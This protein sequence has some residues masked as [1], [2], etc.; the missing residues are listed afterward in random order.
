MPRPLVLMLPPDGVRFLGCFD[1]VNFKE[2]WFSYPMPG[3]IEKVISSMWTYGYI[4]LALCRMKNGTYSIYQSIDLGRSWVEVYNTP[5][6]INDLFFIDFGWVLVSTEEGWLE[7]ND[8]GSTYHVLSIDAPNCKEVIRLGESSLMAY[9]GTRVWLSTNLGAEWTIVHTFSTESPAALA[10][11]WLRAVVGSGDTL[12]KTDNQGGS[13]EVL[14]RWPGEKILSV[15][16]TDDKEWT[17]EGNSYLVRTLNPSTGIVRHYFTENGGQSWSP[18]FDQ[19]YAPS[20]KPVSYA[21]VLQPGSDQWDS[22]VFSAQ[23]RINTAENRQ[24]ISLK[25]SR[26][27]GKDW[28]DIDASQI[29][30]I[31]PG[32]D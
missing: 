11:N 22:L 13:F 14:A 10:G 8:S 29:S 4:H 6:K 1:V 31:P 30:L 16:H 27:D 21:A 3:D 7:S 19:F 24:E 23:T 12:Y 9:D 15:I 25:Y 26:N 2:W 18:R 28:I 32:G 20:D 5:L 17:P